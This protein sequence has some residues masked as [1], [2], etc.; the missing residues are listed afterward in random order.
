MSEELL[1]EQNENI[2]AAYPDKGNHNNILKIINTV[3]N[4]CEDYEVM[5]VS[6]YIH[7]EKEKYI[8]TVKPLIDS[9]IGFG[10]SRTVITALSFEIETVA[11][12]LV[13]SGNELL[14]F[15]LPVIFDV[16]SN[17]YEGGNYLLRNLTSKVTSAFSPDDNL[18]HNSTLVNH[19]Y[20]SHYDYNEIPEIFITGGFSTFD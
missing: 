18:G 5:F 12:F 19:D 3:I 9:A 11:K 13:H 8:N 16:A 10:V 15:S 1:I 20:L 14:K 17:I 4:K 7:L 2:S 6:R